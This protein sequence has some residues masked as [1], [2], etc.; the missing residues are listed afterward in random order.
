MMATTDGSLAYRA[1]I[2]VDMHTA[3][4]RAKNTFLISS[5]TKIERLYEL[6]LTCVQI[7][8]EALPLLDDLFNLKLSIEN[9]RDTVLSMS[10]MHLS[11]PQFRLFSRPVEFV[12]QRLGSQP[13][14]RMLWAYHE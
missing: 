6:K 12:D 14:G 3:L 5:K 7:I 9:L 8:H 13:T 10:T 1:T 11:S 2:A 4:E